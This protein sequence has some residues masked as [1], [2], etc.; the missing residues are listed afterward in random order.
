M[1]S[2]VPPIS[3][4]ASSTAIA[5]AAISVWTVDVTVEGLTSTGTVLSVAFDLLLPS[6]PAV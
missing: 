4:F 3:A 5:A 2:C 1:V 6:V